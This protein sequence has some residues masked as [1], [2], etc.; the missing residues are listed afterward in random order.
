MKKRRSGLII[1]ISVLII[2]GGIIYIV[3][4][5]TGSLTRTDIIKNG[6]LKVSVEAEGLIIR[7]DKIALSTSKANI[8]RIKKDG[9]KLRVGNAAL[10]IKKKKSGKGKKEKDNS[11]KYEDE[12]NIEKIEEIKDV[13]FK[14]KKGEFKTSGILTFY[15]DGN[16]EFCSPENCKKIDYSDFEDMDFDKYKFKEKYVSK[17]SPLFRQTD[18]K[19]WMLLCW[20]DM[21]SK[22]AKYFKVD[23]KLTVDIA[24]NPIKGY[25]LDRKNDGDMIRLII[26]F[27]ATYSGFYKDRKVDC[28]LT[29]MDYSGL[30]IKNTSICEKDDKTSGVYVKTSSGKFIFKE[31]KVITTD[32]EQSIIQDDGDGVKNYDEVL[33]SPGK[34]QGEEI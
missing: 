29:C 30:I 25:I 9:D 2:L 19:T 10:E 27:T 5:V 33:S 15:M 32:G 18:D 6:N 17:G 22:N 20:I 24:G 1:Y 11:E 14:S 28:Q 16:E 12:S 13:T 7:D 3:P 23:E 4:K 31:V 8:K 26:E 21:D 34:Y